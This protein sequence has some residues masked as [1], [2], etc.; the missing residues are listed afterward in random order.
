MSNT[1]KIGYARVSTSDKGQSVDPQILKLKAAGCEVIFSD[2]GESGKKS[3]RPQWDL[4]LASLN[5]GDTLVA[6]RLDRFGRSVQH[7][8]KLSE[9]LAA[10]GIDLVCTDQPIDTTTSVGKL[11]FTI[12]A[13]VAE[14]EASIT[15]ERV[16]DGLAV[17]V[18]NGKTLGAPKAIDDKTLSAAITMRE[19]GMR[20]PEICGILKCAQSTL[21]RAM[22][23]AGG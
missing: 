2:T 23:A 1:R 13:A 22:A 14:F 3:S 15:R 12:L 11:I 5:P 20:I 10:R 17:A 6:V 4:C 21:Y 18:A 19:A 7:L 9:D 8:L 16:L